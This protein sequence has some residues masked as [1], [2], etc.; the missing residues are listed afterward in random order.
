[1][2]APLRERRVLGWWHVGEGDE[3]TAT[4]VAHMSAL[5]VAS[6]RRPSFRQWARTYSGGPPPWNARA[7]VK[8]IRRLIA[9]RVRFAW[10]PD[11][12]EQVTAPARMAEEIDADGYTYGDCDDS[13]T[14]GAA[15]G[16][17]VGLPA[18]FTTVALSPGAPYSHVYAE[19]RALGRWWELDTLREAQGI[20]PDFEPPRIRH[21][22]ALR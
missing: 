4:T 17:A 9:T 15:L 3:G 13:A 16:I 20:P 2:T 1:M 11:G 6:G 14:L 5:A 12:I 8:R 10:D 7:R 18:R 19:L 21:W 22:P